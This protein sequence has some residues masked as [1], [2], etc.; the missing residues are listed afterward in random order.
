MLKNV[1]K[2]G[3]FM[4][5]RH[6]DRQKDLMEH[7]ESTFL[8]R[9]NV[10]KLDLAIINNSSL[11]PK[12]KKKD[13]HYNN[14][15]DHTKIDLKLLN[16]MLNHLKPHYRMKLLSSK[17]FQNVMTNLLDIDEMKFHKLTREEK[18]RSLAIAVQMLSY[19]LNVISKTM[20][21]ELVPLI[22]QQIKPLNLT[23]KGIYKFSKNNNLKD[24]PPFN[25]ITLP[26]VE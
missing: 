2:Y 19:C 25:E 26:I 9:K 21:K 15:V 7:L 10:S 1:E 6:S 11:F 16:F 5:K 8:V 23:L 3:F 17:E 12:N 14:G 22:V 4:R 18:E 20:P 24:L 13:R